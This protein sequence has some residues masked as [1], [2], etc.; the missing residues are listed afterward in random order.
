MQKIKRLSPHEAQKIAAGEVVERP[1]NIVKELL[2]NSIDAGATHITLYAE[3][4][5][6]VLLR[7]TDNGCGMSYDDARLCIEPHATSKINS[8]DDLETLATFGFR[9]E[10]LASIAAV[11]KVILITKQAE[12]EQGIRLAV[13]NGVISDESLVSCNTGTEIIINDLFYNIPARKKFLK[14]N[15]TEWRLI[16]QLMHAFCLDYPHVHFKLLHDEREILNC[17]PTDTV[18]NRATQIWGHGFSGSLLAID[19]YSYDR[20]IIVSGAISNQHYF[21]YDRGSIFFFVNRR[22]VKNIQLSKALLKGYLNILPKDHFPAGFI[23]IEIDTTSIDVNIHPK[24]EE[25][26]FLHPRIVENA[27]FDVVKKR[28]ELHLSQQ[29]GSVTQK[30]AVAVWPAHSTNI[31]QQPFIQYSPATQSFDFDAP[32]FFQPNLS[33]ERSEQRSIVMPVQ[34]GQR[35]QQKNNN[36]TVNQSTLLEKTEQ[37]DHIYHIIGQ[38]KQTYIII[39]NSDGLMLIDQHAAHER[40]LYEL[41]S[42]RFSDVA[43]VQLLFPQ[44]ITLPRDT[45]TLLEP[46]LDIFTSNGID[47]EVFN[48]EQLIVRATPVHMKDHSLDDLVQQAAG[49]IVEYQDVPRDQF[50]KKINEQMHTQMACKAAVKA[51]DELSSEQMQQLVRDLSVT[52]NR[53]TCPHGRPTS[54]TISLTEIERKFKR[55]YR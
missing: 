27:V 4:A 21:R 20:G 17:P 52:E 19:R 55:D 12:D 33:I 44:L 42:Q 5:G 15:E 8:I 11:S 18:I 30:Q 40:I 41:F 6:K 50:F 53:I 7:L 43:T 28:L 48:L 54:W 31:D 32:V 23:F 37:V 34:S 9:G 3:Q 14:T 39:E 51:G 25:I 45:I 38:F 1:A 46:Y 22:W 36:E 49:W 16:Q 24:K 10:A 13:E 2:E 29:L 26:Q 35:D 47:I